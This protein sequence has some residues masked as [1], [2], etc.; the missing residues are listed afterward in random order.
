MEP[1]TPTLCCVMSDVTPTMLLEMY[2]CI[3][4]DAR[5]CDP[6]HV[7]T[8]VATEP[9][10]LPVV[11]PRPAPAGATGSPGPC[12]A[13]RHRSARVAV[14]R[15]DSREMHL[16][17]RSYW[18]T[19]SLLCREASICARRCGPRRPPGNAL[20]LPRRGT[21]SLFL[22]LKTPPT[23]RARRNCT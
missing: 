6:R 16:P 12:F 9:P 23:S 17:C 14:D 11:P 7:A 19:R 18:V 1:T 5:C 10:Q 20:A 13:G 8:F 4:S 21:V 15:A 2:S 3:C 22:T